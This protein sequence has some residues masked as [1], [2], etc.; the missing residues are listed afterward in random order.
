MQLRQQV[1][2][3]ARQLWLKGLIVGDGGLVCAEVHRRRFMVT[4]PGRRRGDLRESDLRIV[5]IGGMELGEERVLDEAIWR[6]HRIAYQIGVERQAAGTE[7][8]LGAFRA[9]V[10][11]TPPMTLALIRMNNGASSLALHGLPSLAI[12]NPEDE[13]TL[14]TQLEHSAAA[15]LGRDGGVF[16]AAADVWDAV[17][18]IERIEHAATIEMACR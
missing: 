18:L 14:K 11:A 15:S 16:C 2:E 13:A 7:Q 6:A 3:A 5:D 4:P 8:D 17:N 9:S 10:H 1:C 12:V